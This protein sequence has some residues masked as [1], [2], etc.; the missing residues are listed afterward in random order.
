MQVD[1]QSFH[2]LLMELERKVWALT[3]PARTI[4]GIKRSGLIPGVFL[5]EKLGLPFFTN[6]ELK[7]P[8]ECPETPVV[9]VDTT[10][11]TGKSLRKACLRLV[12]L[13]IAEELICTAVLFEQRGI[14]PPWQNYLAL[15]AAETIPTFWFQRCAKDE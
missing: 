11:W 6:T 1:I 14:A 7:P 10:C 9:V 12:R 4:V 8:R 3:P 2:E 15:R 13:G 5:S